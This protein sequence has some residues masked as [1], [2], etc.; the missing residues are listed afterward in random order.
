MKKIIT[1]IL[2]LPLLLLSQEGEFDISF[3]GDGKLILDLS[4]DDGATCVAMQPDEKIVIGGTV[5]KSDVSSV[6]LRLD[7][8]G[9]ADLT[10]GTLGIA[11]I[12]FP[13]FDPSIQDVGIQD[14]GKILALSRTYRAS[15]SGVM[16]NRL[17]ANG[18]LDMTFGDTGMV[19]REG[20]F[21]SSYWN[22][23]LPMPGGKFI[24]GGYAYFSNGGVSGVMLGYNENGSRNL[25][26]GDSGMVKFSLN[27]SSVNIEKLFRS[28]NGQIW[29]VGSGYAQGNRNFLIAQF[30]EDGTFYSPFGGNGIATIPFGDDASAYDAAEQGDG[31][32]VLAGSIYLNGDYQFAVSRILTDGTL[33][34][35]FGSNG[36]VT[37]KVLNGDS[38]AV[39][40]SVL[41]DGKILTAGEAE[42]IW[43][44][45]FAIVRYRKDGSLD[46]S[47]N[48][49]GISTK[50]MGSDDDEA[51]AAVMQPNGRLV[52]VGKTFENSFSSNVFTAGRFLGGQG[53]VGITEA[54]V[55]D[56]TVFPN[57]A[58]SYIQLQFEHFVNE[59]QVSLINQSGGVVST[60]QGL[61]YSLNIDVQ[62]VPAGL[63]LLQVQLDNAPSV[64]KKIMVEK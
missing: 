27:G 26:F 12:S 59:I 36:K 17:N 54:E 51:R 32:L 25:A 48:Y 29:A 33:D 5:S 8:Y 9:N 2:F 49:D 7:R 55:Y 44:K 40:V 64:Y 57:P 45:D 46:P 63:Y 39:S 34:Q 60:W 3:N 21:G 35:S 50:N 14:D 38:R 42:G 30:N 41:G 53:T 61:G 24:V 11:E 18:S 62:Q 22:S 6:V 13:D 31:K 1:L 15:E 52:M 56:F 37:T 4:Y 19:Y 10:F 23:I 20:W 47:F 28:K 58:H 16:I 43:N